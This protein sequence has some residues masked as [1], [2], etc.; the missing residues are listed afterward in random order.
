MLRTVRDTLNF[1]L[2][3]VLRQLVILTDSLIVVAMQGIGRRISLERLFP[4]L[5]LVLVLMCSSSAQAMHES[6][7]GKTGAGADLNKIVEG[8]VLTAT[9][10][11]GPFDLHRK[12]KSM[13]GPYISQQ[14]RVGEL[15]SASK[16]V[17]PESMIKFVE[18][19]RDNGSKSLPDKQPVSVSRPAGLVKLVRQKRQL[20][21]LKG[22]KV[23]VLDEQDKP[24]PSSEFFC[25][26]IVFV[27]KD[28]RNH[29]AFPQAELV[30]NERLLILSQGLSQFFFPKRF[31]VP[32]ASDEDWV[33]SFQAAN[34]TTDQH[35]RVKH[36][37]TFYFVKDN[38]T[39]YQFKALH[40]YMPYVAVLQNKGEVVSCS[41][42]NRNLDCMAT[43]S[44]ARAPNSVPASTVFDALGR[45]QA[46]HWVVPP[47]T[48]TYK[49]QLDL[50]PGLA[51]FAA[52]DRKIHAVWCHVHPLCTS[53][54]LVDV[55]GK[56][57]KKVF[58][59]K[60]RTENRKGLEITHIDSIS[61]QAGIPIF[62][63][64]RYELEATY[65]NNT[66]A[67]QDSM[68]NDGVF[69]SDMKFVRPKWADD[70]K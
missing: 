54:S 58:T 2:A 26:L 11:V 56:L 7:S 60:V 19:S 55:T 69:C 61:S 51:S 4:H 49:M 14:L 46:G 66:G 42:K 39:H 38:A 27:D 41:T 48:H 40:W 65:V 62:K 3:A 33:L 6:S 22:L 52:Q 13:E 17:I 70:K 50:Q 10:E 24:L 32:V 37:C 28:F 34:R 63:G 36:R 68:I 20:Y 35:R 15:I 59:A 47:G 29:E 16:V 23:E 31:A 8:P 5:F 1:T 64:H 45:K 21:W 53:S 18:G 43:S 12:Y 30:G 25:H 67:P 57:P 44:G 9:V